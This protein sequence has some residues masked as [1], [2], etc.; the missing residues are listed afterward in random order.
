[1]RS[2]LPKKGLPETLL[3]YFR[4]HSGRVL[5]RDELA[6]QVWKLRLDP[7]SRV[8]DQTVSRIRQQL[9][10]EEQIV[11]VNRHGYLHQRTPER[12]LHR[13]R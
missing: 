12:R 5:A 6:Q 13:G 8:I 2:M 4:V 3:D 1:M 10:P 7:R 11:T 9:S